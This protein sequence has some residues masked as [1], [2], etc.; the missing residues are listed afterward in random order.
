[1][2]VA[3]LCPTLCDAMDY[4]H[5]IL[6]A[7][8][9]EPFHSL[10]D[11]PNPGVKPRSPALQVDSLPAE[12]QGKPKNTGV[13]SLSLL[14]QFFPTQESNWSLLHCRWILYQLSYQVSPHS[15]HTRQIKISLYKQKQLGLFSINNLHHLNMSKNKKERKKTKDR[16]SKEI[17]FSPKITLKITIIIIIHLHLFYEADFFLLTA[18][19][20]F[21]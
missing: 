19:A 2:K 17:V 13:G 11:L 6:Q 12:T 9:L 3:Q 7:R 21:L 4:S 15:F 14:Q 16:K 8:T 10:G 18:F 1:M 5:A 20:C